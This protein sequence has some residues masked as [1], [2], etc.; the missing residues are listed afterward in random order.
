MPPVK[1]GKFNKIT[2]YY[3]KV[4]GYSFFCVSFYRLHL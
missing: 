1:V 3:D 2:T 4:L